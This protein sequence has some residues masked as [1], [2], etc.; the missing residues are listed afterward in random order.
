MVL[1]GPMEAKHTQ[2]LGYLLGVIRAHQAAREG[3]SQPLPIL[4]RGPTQVS[5]LTERYCSQTS[6]SLM[7]TWGKA[8]KQT[9]LGLLE[10]P[11]VPWLL[12]VPGDL[13][14]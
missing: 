1:W 7:L 4:P 12:E 14:Q 3:L 10:V 5:D 11:E 6:A 13:G 2:G 9:D 8:R